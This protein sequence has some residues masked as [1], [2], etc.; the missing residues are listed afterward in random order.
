MAM[1]EYS[2]IPGSSPRIYTQNTYVAKWLEQ[3]A[4]ANHKVLARRKVSKQHTLPIVLQ[5]DTSLARLAELGARDPEIAWVVFQAFWSEITSDGCQP[6]L[7]TLDGLNHA[8]KD[9]AYR[10]PEFEL[11]HAH[12]L[13]IIKHF[14]DYLSG[15]KKLPNGGAV[16]AATT[17]GLHNPSYALSLAIKQQEERQAGK[18]VTQRDPWTKF[19]Q[20]AYDSL[21]AAAV[22]RLKGLSKAEA[23]GLMDYW[24]ASGLLRQRVDEGTVAERWIVAGNGIV[25]ELERGALNVMR[26]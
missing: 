24:A 17:K 5:P 21:Q 18:E 3:I 8:M 20:R 19:D 1:T 14:V 26:I 12:D 6:I 10:S 7:M 16:M 23:R 4:K 13:A 2:P 15:A 25:G 9:S 11:I 22:M